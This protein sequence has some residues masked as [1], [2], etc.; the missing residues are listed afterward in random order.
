MNTITIQLTP[1]PRQLATPLDTISE[2]GAEL[3]LD[4]TKDNG[5]VEIGEHAKRLSIPSLKGGIKKRKVP[6]PTLKPKALYT[7]KFGTAENFI[8]LLP[9]IM[10]STKDDGVI[11]L[12]HS[13]H[14]NVIM[15]PVLSDS[16]DA[17]ALPRLTMKKTRRHSLAS[18]AA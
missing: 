10:G 13:E 12:S 11:F 16:D 1:T 6:Q 17:V 9:A 3:Q 18:R 7:P 14:D 15:F 2:E 8:S 5:F 4:P